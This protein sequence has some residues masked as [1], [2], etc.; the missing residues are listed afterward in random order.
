MS[1]HFVLVTGAAGFVGSRITQK[2]I[3]QGRKVLALDCFLP[4]LYSAELKRSWKNLDSPNL[5]KLE[6][7][8]RHDN[9][10]MLEPYP[11]DSIINQ[12]AMPGLAAD[13][14]N[15]APY[16]ECN[17]SALNRL[18]EFSRKIKINSFI[19]ASTS[20]VYGKRAIGSEDQ[21]LNPTSPYGVSK[22]AAEKLILAYSD[23]YSIPAKIL[24]YFSI[25]GP[26]QRPDMAYAKII[27]ALLH[28]QEFNVYGDGEQKRSNTY[29]DDIVDAT[30]L[31][32][33]KAP[34]ASVLNIC[35]DETIS[36]N[37]AISILEKHTNRQLK[38]IN[39]S[40]RIGDQRDTSGLNS[41]AKQLLS[42]HARVGIEEGL[43]NQV[44]AHPL[45]TILF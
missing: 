42:W 19:Q 9:F 41:Q 14:S 8:V 18:L 22:L 11:I 30:L 13:W 37:S 38:R 5:V 31:A 39:S 4:N 32:E 12:A 23:W 33:L 44:N 15:F 3:E 1:S 25:Y 36:L 7:D 24:R 17:L 26:N 10:S 16:Y 34:T 20:S 43:L 27:D 6:F 45:R 2:L 21:E 40:G 35:G 28:D 29:I